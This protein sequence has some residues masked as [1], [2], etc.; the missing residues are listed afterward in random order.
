[1]NW[2]LIGILDILNK[3][4]ALILVISTTISGYY[5]EFGGFAVPVGDPTSRLLAT[6]LGFVIGVVLAALVSGFLATVINI[7]RE[8]TAIREILL[9]RSPPMSYP[10]R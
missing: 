2:L 8:M 3:L 10:V 6:I 1:M 7:S 5:G 4:L 9:A